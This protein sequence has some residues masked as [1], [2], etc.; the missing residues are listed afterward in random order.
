MIGTR[1]TTAV[2]ILLLIPFMAFAVKTQYKGMPIQ[3]Y[4][5]NI[6]SIEVSDFLYSDANNGRG[7]NL[8]Y[9]DSSN[10]NAYLIAPTGGRL[11]SVPGLMIGTFDATVTFNPSSNSDYTSAT[12]TITHGK[13]LKTGGGAAFD[14]EL[15]VEYKMN[16]G[17]R[18]HD[19]VNRFC[20]STD[21]SIA[22]AYEKSIVIDMVPSNA[23]NGMCSIKDGG[24]YFRLTS[25]EPVNVS[26]DYTSNITFMLQ[27]N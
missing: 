9:E 18:L 3:G 10:S 20:L 16:D 13:L 25:E 2:L 27:G 11:L 8:N 22:T 14:Y 6:F 15:A 24:I 1:K 7:I 19:T 5:G 23:T 4:I 12:L 26:G 17:D 21:S